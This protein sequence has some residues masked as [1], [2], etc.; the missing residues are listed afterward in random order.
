MCGNAIIRLKWTPAYRKNYEALKRWKEENTR[1]FGPILKSKTIKPL[2]K[3]S[4]RK[5]VKYEL[6]EDLDAWF[7]ERYS[8]VG[9]AS[10][11]GEDHVSMNDAV[12]LNDKR[13]VTVPGKQNVRTDSYSEKASSSDSSVQTTNILSKT[14]S[15]LLKDIL[16]CKLSA[17][18]GPFVEELKSRIEQK[19]LP[20]LPTVT[21][22]L[23][24]TRSQ[25]SQFF[26]DR[27]KVQM[28][29]ELGEEGFQRLQQGKVIWGC[30]FSLV[31]FLSCRWHKIRQMRVLHVH[32]YSKA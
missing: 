18:D 27:W 23:A 4:K 13:N 32:V 2:G 22:I 16:H 10:Q 8:S 29:A 6:G 9:S 11:E 28:I 24:K 25:E 30:S 3:K 20:T 7:N 26:L 15:E 31:H 14:E 5:S 17:E 19:K 21:G 1:L 12:H